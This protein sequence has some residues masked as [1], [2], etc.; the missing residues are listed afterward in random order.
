MMTENWTLLR[1]RR[2]IE[3]RESPSFSEKHVRNHAFSHLKKNTVARTP[4]TLR[5]L[6][7]RE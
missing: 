7:K 1:T 2:A 4:L 6:H 3:K 5:Q